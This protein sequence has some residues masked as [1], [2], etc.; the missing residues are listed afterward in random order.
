M[1]ELVIDGDWCISYK[2]GS[3]NRAP[4]ASRLLLRVCAVMP[5]PA[6]PDVC[7]C[8]LLRSPALRGLYLH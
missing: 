7:C 8:W 1:S 5:C 4:V 2:L 3:F 6:C